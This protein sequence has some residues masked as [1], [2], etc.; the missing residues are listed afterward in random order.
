MRMRRTTQQP[1]QY[2]G[3]LGYYTHY[4][5][6]AF[7]LL[8]L[9]ARYYDPGIGR[10]VSRDPAKDGLN[11][12]AYVGDGPVDQADPT[13]LHGMGKGVSIGVG[14]PLPIPRRPIP[15]GVQVQCV[16]ITCTDKNGGQHHGLICSWCVGLSTRGLSVSAGERRS[17]CEALEDLTGSAWDFG[18]GRLVGPDVTIGFNR[19]YIYGPPSRNMVL[20]GGAWLMYCR[21]YIVYRD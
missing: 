1:Y 2:V 21:S 11:V 19:R 6:P 7:D 5:N 16:E 4:Q 8:Q 17:D 12:Y 14:F 20:P 18:S 13:G 15:A 3:R 10:F 9:G